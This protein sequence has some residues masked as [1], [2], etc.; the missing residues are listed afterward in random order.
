MASYTEKPSNEL[1][2]VLTP[3]WRVSV[4]EKR[5]PATFIEYIS[6]V[7]GEI[8]IT[9]HQLGSGAFVKFQRSR[10]NHHF[11]FLDNEAGFEIYEYQ[12]S[13]LRQRRYTTV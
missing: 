11:P 5:S 13:A 12:K 4:S 2:G 8:Q 7:M 1:C 10:N 9:G 6:Y 3:F